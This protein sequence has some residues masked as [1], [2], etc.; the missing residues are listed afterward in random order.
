MLEIIVPVI[1]ATQHYVFTGWARR[2][3]AKI[4]YLIK[5]Q[6]A[7]LSY[8][9][10]NFAI[11]VLIVCARY[12]SEFLPIA[13]VAKWTS[14]PKYGSAHFTHSDF[15]EGDLILQKGLTVRAA[16]LCVGEMGLAP[17]A[18]LTSNAISMLRPRLVAMVGMCCGFASVKCA[19]PSKLGDIIV[20]RESANWEEGKIKSSKSRRTEFKNRAVIRRIDDLH[21]PIVMRCVESARKVFE[22]ALASHYQSREGVKLFG[23]HN[24]RNIMPDIK[25]GML[26][27]GSSVVASALQVR[28]ILERFPSALGLEMEMFAVFVAADLAIGRRPG[29]IG[30]K[31]V[32]DLGTA[33]KN[34]KLQSFASVAS[35]LTL[36]AILTK[37][38]SN[39]KEGV[40]L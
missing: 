10:N 7:A 24:G 37:I 38:F 28:K 23:E 9:Y 25:F 22:P 36:K 35:F 33:L 20:V 29:V 13:S 30:V 12:E 15:V 3:A 40:S 27:S 5:A 1:V 21:R 19:S 2:I 8:H 32:A 6:A 39:R 18:A 26:V 14:P 4:D 34:N 17:S 11:D 31:G 16:I